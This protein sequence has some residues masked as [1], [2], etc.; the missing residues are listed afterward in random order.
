MVQRR[1]QNGTGFGGERVLVQK[2]TLFCTG[3]ELLGRNGAEK[4]AK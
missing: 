2:K 1:V 4:G 3:E